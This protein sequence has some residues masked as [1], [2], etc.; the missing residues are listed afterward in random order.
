MNFIKYVAA[1]GLTLA[2]AAC[3]GGGGDPGTSLVSPAVN[4]SVSTDTTNVPLD[5]ATVPESFVFSLDK[6]T[7]SNSGSDKSLLTVT[8]LDAA[9]N[10]L[11]GVPV[12]VALNSGVY[13]PIKSTT[14]ASGQIT[15]NVSIGSDKSNRT[16][17]A[18]ISV[19]SLPVGIASVAVI[20]SQV[21]LTAVPATPIP[22]ERVQLAIKATDANGA[23]IVGARIQLGGTLGYTQLV[24][25]DVSGN[26]SAT[27]GASPNTIGNYSITA[28][29]LGVNASREIQVIGLDGGIPAAIG[30]ISSA[31]LAATPNT[32][33]P[34]T[35]GGTLNRSTLRAVFQNASNQ[36]IP[37]VR[38]RF[39]IDPPG[40]GSGEQIS[41]GDNIVYSDVNG[42][43]VADYIAGTRSSPTDGVIVR[44]CHSPICLSL[45][46]CRRSASF[47]HIRRQQ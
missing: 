3:G 33:S 38:V 18:R 20:G 44:A 34:N 31:S 9:R 32:I 8:V 39:V 15:G 19:L 29:G 45:P 47:Y 17:E 46:D 41:T 10:V 11:V 40:L 4:D 30:V 42:V 37:N 43:A 36:A 23:G 6:F 22:G 16:I 24:E 5:T 14:D 26:A 28:V 13:T 7:L 21:S 27:L 35:V 25:T 2:L 1:L 12:A